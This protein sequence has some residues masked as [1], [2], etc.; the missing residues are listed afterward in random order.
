MDHNT[1]FA[2]A[3]PIG[4]AVYYYLVIK[5]LARLCERAWRSMVRRVRLAAGR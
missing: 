3:F 2:I 5:P 4:S 1:L